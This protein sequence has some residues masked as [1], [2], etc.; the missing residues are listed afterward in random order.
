MNSTSVRGAIATLSAVA[1]CLWTTAPSVS[2][3]AQAPSLATILGTAG[4]YVSQL[5]KDLDGVVFEED[6]FQQ[7]QGQAL[8]AR[9]LKSDI[10]VL[11]D[12][13][14]G[15][16][17]FRDTTS[18]DG[19]PVRDR[20]ARIADIFTKPDGNAL[21]QARRIVREGARF[22]IEA[23]GLKIDRT[24]NLPMAALAFLRAENQRRSTFTPDR[25]DV[26]SGRT[27]AIRFKETAK[28]RMIGTVDDAAA[29][30][31]FW[32][33]PET[34]RVTRTE[35][36]IETRR[37]SSL[38]SASIGVEYGLIPSLNLWLPKTMD[39]WYQATTGS[40]MAGAITG[41][42]VYENFRK[43]NVAVEEKAAQ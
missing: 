28:P 35:L 14:V 43:F 34:G 39:E 5:G 20:Q 24:I 41:H 38:V 36:T 17:E 18:V 8:V 15:W 6:Y 16:V 13:A 26:F 27:V 42:A 9:R 29:Q 21:E 12:N 40:Q 37:G 33:V 1:V 7:A 2:A 3:R 30:G 19:K 32:I 11:S 10:A 4:S 23:V 22:N 31:V 25:S